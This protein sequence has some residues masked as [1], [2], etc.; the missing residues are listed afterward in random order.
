MCGR[1]SIQPAPPA[2]GIAPAIAATAGG[3]DAELLALGERFDRLAAEEARVY[4]L[5][6]PYRDAWERLPEEMKAEGQPHSKEEWDA[7]H[8]PLEHLQCRP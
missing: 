6:G 3:D 4:E 2:A 7:R 5:E 8:R 1:A